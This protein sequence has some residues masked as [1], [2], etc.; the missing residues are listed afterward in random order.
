MSRTPGLRFDPPR[1]PP[2]PAVDWSLARAFAPPPAPPAATALAP[3]AL[4][5]ELAA[6]AVGA[7]RRLDLDVRIAARCDPAALAAE[8]GAGLA[9]ELAAAR[10]RTV[11]AGLLLDELA[12]QVAAVAAGLGVPLALLKYGAL[13][14]SGAAPTGG[15]RA[16]DLDV[17]VPRDRVRALQRRLVA[18]GF[19]EAALPDREHQLPPLAAPRRGAVLELHRLVLGVRP[20]GSGG[21][22]SADFD[23]LDRAGLLR[24]VGP[25]AGLP[26]DVRLPAPEVLAAHC[27]VHGLVHHGARPDAYPA[28]RMLADLVDLGIAGDGGEA[29]A[30]RAAELTAADVTAV[31]AAAVAGLCRRLAAGAG[32]LWTG[33]DSPEARLLDHLVGGVFDPAYR[34][35]LR[36]GSLAPLS[37]RG[38]LRRVL[39]EAAGSL[40]LTRGQVDAIYGRPAGRWGYLGR[41]LARPFDLLGRLLRYA[42]AARAVRRGPGGRRNRGGGGAG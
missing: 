14:W 33:G 9:A 15:R 19:A 16:G 26:G 2:D 12:H 11:A 4:P 6:A 5:P 17:L 20:G 8:L 21:G 30:R 32:A 25:E 31:E 42:R 41:R 38:R 28:M 29:L 10:L 34:D 39:A 35:A 3:P 40:W 1:R 24:P 36:L 18:A 13:E 7:A 23:T 37:D 27:L 22:R